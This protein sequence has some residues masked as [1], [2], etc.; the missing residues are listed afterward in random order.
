VTPFTKIRQRSLKSQPCWQSTLNLTLR[1]A[2][3]R[4]QTV[5]RSGLIQGPHSGHLRLAAAGRDEPVDYGSVRR[6]LH[7]ANTGP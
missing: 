3:K 4:R 2:G 1:R 5:E 7:P 6:R